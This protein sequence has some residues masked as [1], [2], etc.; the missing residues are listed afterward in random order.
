MKSFPS[1]F[2]RGGN[3]AQYQGKSSP[4]DINNIG[5]SYGG[6]T[7]EAFDN[8]QSKNL[9]KNY[10]VRQQL[11][12]LV[13]LSKYERYNPNIKITKTAASNN[14]ENKVMFENP[15]FMPS[16]MLRSMNTY[17][18]VYDTKT[19][20][21]LD[22][23]KQKDKN[24]TDHKSVQSSQTSD[25]KDNSDNRTNTGVDLRSTELTGLDIAT[26]SSSPAMFNPLFNVQAVGMTKNVPLLFTYREKNQLEDIGNC[27]I[28]RLIKDSLKAD[29]PLGAARY[30]LVDF[31][32]CKDLG[33][34][35]NNH[36]ITLRKFPLPVGDYIYEYAGNRKY[37]DGHNPWATTGDVGRLVSWFG[38]DD[39]KLEDIC[40]YETEFTWKEITNQIQEI[41]S[42]EDDSSR[43]ILGKISNSLNPAYNSYTLK[44]GGASHDLVT[45]LG[46]RIH[47]NWLTKSSPDYR[48]MTS[49]YSDNNRV[50]T[51]M[52]TVQ[53]NTIPEGRLK[54]SQEITL[55]FSYKLR[56]YEDINPKSAFL[57]LIGNI[58]EVTYYRGHY[59]KG[60]ARLIGPPVNRS[61]WDTATALIDN[62]WER[63]GGFV[64][65]MAYG[66]T[67]FPDILGSLSNMAQGVMDAVSNV[68][69]KIVDQINGNNG[70]IGRTFYDI[71][72]KANNDIRFTDAIKRQIK[73]KFGR[74]AMYAMNSLIEG[75]NFGP[76]HLTIG[77][78]YN[79]IMSI[80]NLCLRNATIT[81]SGPLG[82]DDFP[83]EIKVTCTL[84]PA[85][86]RDLVEIS[87]YYTRGLNALYLD[88]SKQ[89]VSDFYKDQEGNPTKYTQLYAQQ[90][91][92]GTQDAFDTA[93]DNNINNEKGGDR[94]TKNEINYTQSILSTN[95]GIQDM[96]LEEMSALENANSK[97]IIAGNP[98]NSAMIFMT[99]NSTISQTTLAQ[100][101]VG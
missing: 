39:N 49:M 34:V 79:P 43:D 14:G 16:Y 97:D 20:V 77:N 23:H 1:T 60:E 55:N 98:Y 80:G 48:Q 59:W 46:G 29:S 65:S 12:K 8:I 33:R 90:I 44:Y 19:N 70:D 58:L 88:K 35:S 92:T 96:M 63:L 62:A 83:S 61:A 64:K 30:R 24:D 101:Q 67:S 93:F 95:T 47:E 32:Y 42:Q 78:P 38:T 68:G 13:K 21:L 54:L 57:D 99:N 81:H 51:P 6:K 22:L 27:T 41:E 87:K 86:S 2:N 45:T 100:A 37:F 66:D 25:D 71:L 10:Y 89:T 5:D 28:D 17:R 56:A 94:D 3:S 15:A 7:P 40:K 9:N 36:L 91:G 82:I 84:K 52:N 31:M 53:D 69:Q 73:N 18:F 76:W 75:D 74:P 50:Y 4:S 85:R 11:F 26:V 72:A